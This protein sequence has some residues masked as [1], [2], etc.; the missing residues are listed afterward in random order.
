MLVPVR[1][2]VR[3]APPC[4]KKSAI[5]TF[6]KKDLTKNAILENRSL[7]TLLMK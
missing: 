2:G 4:H 7:I 1:E 3:T 5:L 6:E